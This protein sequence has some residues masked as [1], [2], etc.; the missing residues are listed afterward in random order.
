MFTFLGILAVLMIINVVLL[1]F[2]VNGSMDN[3]R[4]TFRKIS[5]N[6]VIKF[7]LSAEHSDAKYKKAI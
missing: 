1:I 6:K 3:F 2:S 5:E 7:P 4:K